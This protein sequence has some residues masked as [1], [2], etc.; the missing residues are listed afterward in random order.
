MSSNLNNLLAAYRRT[1]YTAVTPLGTLVLRIGEHHQAMDALLS[2]HQAKDWAYLTAWNPGSHPLSLA[3]NQQRQ[4]TLE[5]ALRHRAYSI[6]PG[7]GQPDPEQDSHWTAEASVLVIGIPFAAAHTL[8]QRFGQ[9]A[10]VH[11]QRGGIAQLVQV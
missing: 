9:C 6:Y 3:D 1:S 11:G 7:F 4:A 8:A 10:F 2:A 5:Q